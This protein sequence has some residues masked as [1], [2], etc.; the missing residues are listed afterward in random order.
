MDLFYQIRFFAVGAQASQH[1]KL[2]FK[3]LLGHEVSSR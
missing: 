1:R 2:Q 3:R